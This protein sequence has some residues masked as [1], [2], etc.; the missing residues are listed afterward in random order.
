MVENFIYQNQT[1]K[2]LKEVTEN[3]IKLKLKKKNSQR[4]LD[5]LVTNNIPEKPHGLG[6]EDTSISHHP[7]RTW[8]M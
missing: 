8:H 7:Y 4:T 5:I 2:K 1:I 3:W 6:K